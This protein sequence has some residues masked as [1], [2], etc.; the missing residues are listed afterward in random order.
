[1]Q[2]EV[3]VCPRCSG[4]GCELIPLWMGEGPEGPCQKCGGTRKVVQRPIYVEVDPLTEPPAVEPV[5]KRFENFQARVVFAGDV[6]GDQAPVSDSCSKCGGKMAP[7]KAI[8][9]TCTGMPDF[10]GGDVLTLSPGGPGRLVECL[11]C[12]KCGHSV[13]S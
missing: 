3:V 8:A 11:K 2:V 1:M 4:G 6:L 5:E 7:G 10:P 13:S 12:Q 9:Q